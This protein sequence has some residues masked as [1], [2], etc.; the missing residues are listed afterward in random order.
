M[1][2]EATNYGAVTIK[3]GAFD[4]EVSRPFLASFSTQ[5]SLIHTYC[6]AIKTYPTNR[7]TQSNLN[8]ART[9][10]KRYLGVEAHLKGALKKSIKKSKCLIYFNE[11][12]SKGGACSA[13]IT[14][15][16]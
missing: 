5:F 11:G 2:I 16:E 13:T 4:E 3:I 14:F 6:L 15:Y 8:S 7:S 10:L 12:V 1:L 9:S